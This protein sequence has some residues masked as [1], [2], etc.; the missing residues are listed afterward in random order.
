MATPMNQAIVNDA[1]L[2]EHKALSTGYVAGI[3]PFVVLIFLLGFVNTWY[4][5]MPLRYYASQN[6][7]DK[8]GKYIQEKY[9]ICEEKCA[10]KENRERVRSQYMNPG[11]EEVHFGKDTRQSGRDWAPG[12]AEWV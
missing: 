12:G 1:I 6:I 2:R 5:W 8:F 3:I 7:I 9:K 11:L 10:A 4:I